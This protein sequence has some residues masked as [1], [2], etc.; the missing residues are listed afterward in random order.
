M[1]GRKKKKPIEP[2]FEPADYGFTV[3]DPLPDKYTF[4][5][6]VVGTQYDN[7][8]GSHRQDVLLNVAEAIKSRVDETTLYHHLSDDDI[9][10]IGKTVDEIDGLRYYMSIVPTKYN[11]ENAYEVACKFGVIGFMPKYS[12]EE[13]EAIAPL[14]RKQSVNV[15]LKGGKAKYYDKE[16]DKMCFEW[17]DYEAA[18]VV[19]FTEPL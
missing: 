17:S 7:P 9:K 11:G 6:K 2:V 15:R 3:P 12:I 10:D 4:Y 14:Y 1:F 18:A 19:T 13:Y 5:F 16:L 8:D